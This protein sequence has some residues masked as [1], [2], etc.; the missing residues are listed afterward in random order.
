VADR[1]LDP[2]RQFPPRALFGSDRALYQALLPVQKFFTFF[3]LVDPQ[4]AETVKRGESG[5]PVTFAWYLGFG[6][7][8]YIPG[9]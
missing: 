3:L 8:I 5:K 4:F 7:I 1:C 9:P 2:R 6:I